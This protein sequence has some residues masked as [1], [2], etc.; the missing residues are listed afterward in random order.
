MRGEAIETYTILMGLR[1]I[2]LAYT[3]RRYDLGHRLTVPW[4]Y[5]TNDPERGIP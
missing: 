1:Y 4:T 3:Y 5:S 2:V